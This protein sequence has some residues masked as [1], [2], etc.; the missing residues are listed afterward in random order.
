MV[1]TSLTPAKSFVYLGSLFFL[2]NVIQLKVKKSKC[3]TKINR[4]KKMAGKFE[5]EKQNFYDT[6]SA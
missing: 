1:K 5:F 4:E 6:L 2:Q 3:R